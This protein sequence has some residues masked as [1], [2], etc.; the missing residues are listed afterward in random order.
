MSSYRGAI[1]YP[2]SLRN[3]DRS[4]GV[5]G[6]WESLSPADQRCYKGANRGTRPSQR[7]D[8]ARYSRAS[9]T[10]HMQAIT[11]SQADG[12]LRSGSSNLFVQQVKPQIFAGHVDAW[13]RFRH[14]A[15]LAL[16]CSLVVRWK[17]SDICN[18]EVVTLKGKS[19]HSTTFSPCCC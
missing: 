1:L 13:N 14:P 16:E 6:Y 18:F 7:A 2:V 3:E 10:A 17:D 12:T 9:A 5:G 15:S 19:T 8:W 4:S 11:T